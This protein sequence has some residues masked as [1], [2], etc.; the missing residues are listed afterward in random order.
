MMP[1]RYKLRCFL[2]FA[3][4]GPL[5]EPSVPYNWTCGAIGT[6]GPLWSQ[7]GPGEVFSE[8][9]RL[10]RGGARRIPVASRKPARAEE[11]RHVH[12]SSY[13]VLLHYFTCYS[14]WF[15]DCPSRGYPNVHPF[16]SPSVPPPMVSYGILF[17][18]CPSSSSPNVPF[19]SFTL[20]FSG[21]PECPQCTLWAPPGGSPGASRGLFGSSWGHRSPKWLQ[22][23]FPM[24]L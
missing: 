11:R 20:V 12:V 8:T 22:D 24:P 4:W 3:L 7:P 5:R 2:H 15:S 21:F 23:C 9:P 10:P 18:E 6:C 14:I 1:K 19:S 16:S 13:D 17:P